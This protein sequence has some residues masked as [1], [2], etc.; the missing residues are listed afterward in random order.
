[1]SGYGTGIGNPVYYGSLA[2][3]QRRY[4]ELNKARIKNWERFYGDMDGTREGG[5]VR[6]GGRVLVALRGGIDPEQETEKEEENVPK[7][8]IEEKSGKLALPVKFV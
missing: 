7:E 1:M 5:E 3:R 4:K 2:E 8:G 6:K